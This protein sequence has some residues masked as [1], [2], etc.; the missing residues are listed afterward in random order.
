MGFIP[1]WAPNIHPMLIHFPIVFLITAVLLDAL[2]IVFR[3]NSWLHSAA[4]F[5][6]AVGIVSLVGVYFSGQ[7]AADSVKVA[8]SVYPAIS[9]HANWALRSVWFWIALVAIR[10]ALLFREY[11][12]KTLVLSGLVLVG[13]V[14]NWFIF[15]TADQ[16]AALVYKLGVGVKAVQIE[17]TASQTTELQ[18]A[19]EAENLV[20]LPDGT[21]KWEIR[22]DALWILK[23]MLR[24]NGAEG[25]QVITSIR[26]D[27]KNRPVLSFV[28]RDNP[29]HFLFPEKFQ[30]LSLE[31][32]VN[33]K[34]F[35]GSLYLTHHF[36]DSLNYDFLR[37]E[38]GK[39]SL[40]RLV[41]GKVKILGAKPVD[42]NGW[43]T[44]KV[45]GTKG[46]FRGYLNGELVVHGHGKDYP[47]GAVGMILNGRGEVLL[48]SMVVKPL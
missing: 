36:L 35:Q 4:L 23:K 37:V 10:F 21:I 18:P 14:G 6:Y 45:V 20:R 43:T 42:L 28:L 44:L 1:E 8:D 46:H 5:F 29:T 11:D 31:S 47:A 34:G 15:R 12:R 9:D 3:K 2:N 24:W 26:K 22:E 33:L 38:N 41:Q 40:G 32:V 48:K 7:Q 19:R 39:M 27:E 25:H 17:E 30:S 16:G 13:I